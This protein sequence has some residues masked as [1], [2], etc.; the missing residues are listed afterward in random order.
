[1]RSLVVALT[2][3]LSSTLM[4]QTDVSYHRGDTVRLQ[5][6][7]QKP[8]PDPRIIAVPGDRVRI[9]TSG[10][11]VNDIPLTWVS[12]DFTANYGARPWDSMVPEGQYVVIADY[13]QNHDVSQFLGFV[14]ANTIV[15]RVE[16][17]GVVAA[18]SR[19]LARPLAR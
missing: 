12:R 8:T 14:F 4:A 15:G 2:V 5:L 11:F 13:R 9:N 18:P 1:M 6:K 16:E 7:D 10:V 3:V 17:T 19:P